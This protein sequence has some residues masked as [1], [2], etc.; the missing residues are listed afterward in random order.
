MNPEHQACE[1]P[2]EDHIA[3]LVE[4]LRRPDARLSVEGKLWSMCWGVGDPLNGIVA[5][6]LADG[7]VKRPNKAQEG[8]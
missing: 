3:Y 7:I 6:R 4:Y 5:D 1:T 8:Q 2:V